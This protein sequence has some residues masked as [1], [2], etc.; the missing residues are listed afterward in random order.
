MS[1]CLRCATARTISRGLAEALLSDLNRKHD[2]RVAEI[3]PAVLDAFERHNWPG[4]VR[5]IRNVMER[6]VILAGEGTI[7]LSIC[8]RF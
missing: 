7:E 4:N 1:T 2:C 3:S 8:P 6:A 5:E